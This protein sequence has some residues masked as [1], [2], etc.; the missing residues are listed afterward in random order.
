MVGREEVGE[1]WVKKLIY[2]CLQQVVGDGLT[3]S[4]THSTC[5][6]I[7]DIKPR[8]C[9]VGAL[10]QYGGSSANR[11]HWECLRR[12]WRRSTRSDVLPLPGSRH[13]PALY[14]AVRSIS[15]V[16]PV[17]YKATCTGPE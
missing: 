11:K 5:H 16:L 3:V 13:Y 15:P 2:R 8:D 10:C 6:L 17:W 12:Q 1:G 9:V 4:F 14:E 7:C